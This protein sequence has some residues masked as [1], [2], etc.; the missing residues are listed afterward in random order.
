MPPWLVAWGASLVLIVSFSLLA[1][2]WQRPRLQRE[3]WRPLP[4]WMG[5]ICCGR[6]ARFTAGIL[7]V[8][9]LALVIYAG[10]AGRQDTATNFAI[11]FVFVT[12][13]IGMPLASAIFGNVFSFLSPWRAFGELVAHLGRRWDI[14]SPRW[15][16]PERLGCWPALIVIFS[17]GWLELVGGVGSSM[18]SPKTVA[19]LAL[20]YTGWTLLGMY[21]FGVRVWNERG[22]GFAVYFEM[23]SRLSSFTVQGGR[24]GIR[25]FLSGAA[26]WSTHRGAAALVLLAIGMTTFDGAQEGVLQPVIR[27]TAEA[28]IEGGMSGITSFRIAGTL[29]MLVVLGLVGGLYL[30]GVK[31]MRTIK[32]SPSLRTLSLAF[33]HTLI[34][35]ALAYLVAHYFSFLIF[36]E[37]AQFT[38]LLSDPLGTGSDLF[39]GADAGIDYGILGTSAI[40]GVQVGVLIL[41]HVVGLMLAHDRAIATYRN[42]QMAFRSQ[43]W[44]LGVMITFTCLGLFLLSQGNA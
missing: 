41:G 15:N 3:F 14:P 8:G 36:Q 37:Q 9:C 35:I 20:V 30:I 4:R 1:L 25:R 18:I 22:E 11:T 43:F 16:Y 31:G 26:S 40:W 44:M 39:G 12:F 32:G 6:F 24:L 17:F 21:A 10:L 29:W 7:G 23:F 33:A 19:I 38:Y 13:W 34:P 28:F 42:P 27:S 5:A 2:L